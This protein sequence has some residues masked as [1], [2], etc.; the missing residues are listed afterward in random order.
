MTYH[1]ES[2]YWIGL[3]N[4]PKDEGSGYYWVDGT[5]LN[6]TNWA[7][8]EPDNQFGVENCG[9]L[10][11]YMGWSWNDLDGEN[12]IQ[13]FVCEVLAGVPKPTTQPP[14]NPAPTTTTSIG[15]EHEC[16]DETWM[17]YKGHCYKAFDAADPIIG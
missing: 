15:P 3:K 1:Y 11:Q 2:A 12:N 10:D 13:G 9:D 14:T 4:D 5:P 16:Q 6:Y 8:G 7:E 17:K